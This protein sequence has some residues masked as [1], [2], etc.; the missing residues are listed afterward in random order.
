MAV[1]RI[2]KEDAVRALKAAGSR[3]I[4]AEMIEKDIESG[5]PINEDGTIDLLNYA[6]WILKGNLNGD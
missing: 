2:S 4:S 5:L 6:A 1:R 3:T